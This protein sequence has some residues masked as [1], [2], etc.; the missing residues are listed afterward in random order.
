LSV[1]KHL[2]PREDVVCHKSPAGSARELIEPSKDANKLPDSIK[3]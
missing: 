3:N 1:F 2:T